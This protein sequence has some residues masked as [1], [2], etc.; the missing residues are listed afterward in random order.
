MGFVPFAISPIGSHCIENPGLSLHT[1]SQLDITM[2]QW[3]CW[4][5][6]CIEYKLSG[7]KLCNKRGTQV[8]SAIRNMVVFV[9]PEL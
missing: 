2:K 5:L 1:V 3:N 9:A 8:W 6:Y 7:G 4:I